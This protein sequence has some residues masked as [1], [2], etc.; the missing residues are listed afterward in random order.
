MSVILSKSL[1]HQNQSFELVVNYDPKTNTVGDIKSIW[2][3]THGKQ[4]PIG[5]LMMQ[6][7]EPAVNKIIDETDWRE[8]YRAMGEDEGEV[9]PTIMKSIAPFIK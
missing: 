2:L 8:V 5:N 4:I 7:F 3:I 1:T 9:H 6:F